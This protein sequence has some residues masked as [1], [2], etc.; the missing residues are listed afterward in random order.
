MR[1][2]FKYLLATATT[3][4]ALASCAKEINEPSN[5]NTQKPTGDGFIMTVKSAAGDTKTVIVDEDEGNSYGINWESTDDLGVYE[6]ANDVVQSKSTS[7]DVELVSG[8]ETATFTFSLPTP[9]PTAPYKYAFVHPADAL[10]T[11][12][13]NAQSEYTVCLKQNQTFR[14]NSFDPSADVLIS[15][16]ITEPT[17]RPSVV[18]AQFGRVGATAR[19]VIKCPTTTETIQSITLSTTEGNISGYYTLNPSTGSLSNGIVSGQGSV[20][21]TPAATTTFT[22]DVVVWFRLAAIT[23]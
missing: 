17:N 23:L 21:L 8:G 1:T 22:G 2:V 5:N 4:A 13:I 9:A 20:V 7:D 14:A 19:M 10:G 15:R 16:L 11:T 6:V 12:E 18:T 3:V